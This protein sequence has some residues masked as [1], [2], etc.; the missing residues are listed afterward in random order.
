MFVQSR[1]KL[2]TKQPLTFVVLYNSFSWIW[3]FFMYFRRWNCILQTHLR[4]HSVCLHGCRPYPITCQEEK[5]PAGASF[6]TC[7]TKYFKF[8]PVALPGGPI[9]YVECHLYSFDQVFSWSWIELTVLP[10]IH[11]AATCRL[12]G[13][14]FKCSLKLRLM[15]F[16]QRKRGSEGEVVSM[17]YLPLSFN[18]W[19]RLFSPFCIAS[20]WFL[21]SILAEIPRVFQ[22]PTGKHI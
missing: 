2:L 16:R 1:I 12:E 8:T 3:I 19:V 21:V 22:P 17:P 11:E 13:V 18:L 15:C 14:S 20:T 5:V 7:K 6:H 9:V 4:I 10:R